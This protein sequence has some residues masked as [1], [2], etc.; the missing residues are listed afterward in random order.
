MTRKVRQNGSQV[1][2]HVAML[3][4]RGM[5]LIPM[6]VRAERGVWDNATRNN[7]REM[8]AEGIHQ[9][10]IM[11]SEEHTSELQSLGESRMPSSA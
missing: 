5:G 10:T 6:S 8:T 11:R 2:H 3:S 9:Q 7:H 1:E 4:S